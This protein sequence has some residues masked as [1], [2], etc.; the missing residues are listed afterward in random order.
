[1]S[2]ISLKTPGSIPNHKLQRNLQL[3]SKFISNDGGDEGITIDNSGNTTLSAIAEIGSDTDKF[4]MSDSG[5]VKY[6][7][8]DNLKTFIGVGSGDITG[9][10]IT[11]DSG[12]GSKAE[13][14]G[15][16]ADFSILGSSGVGVTNSGT[17]ITAVA[18]PAEIDHDS[19]NN[20]VANEHIDHTSITLTAG[21]GLTGGGDI[22]SNRS[23]AV[24][25]DDST[26]E[27]NS[28]SLRVKDDGI[29]YAKIQNMTDARMLG[30]NAGSDGVI[31]EMTQANVLSFLGVEAGANNVT[32]HVTNDANDTMAGDLT[33]DS[34]GTQLKLQHN[35][36]DYATFTVANTGD[37]TIATIGDGTTDS[38]LI[39]DADGDIELNADGGDITF[40]DASTS[41]GSIG[42]AGL[43]LP[44]DSRVEWG[45]AAD[46]IYADASD[47]HISKDD[48][49][50]VTFKDDQVL[51]EV[52][53]KIKEAASAVAD[54]A[55]YG[56]I[57]IKTAT[58]NELYFTNDAGNDVQIT[59][60]SGL[61]NMP[62]VLYTQ[63]Q[64]DV[65]INKHYLPL[66]GYFEQS[67]V[68]NEPTGMIAPFNMKLQKATMRCNTDISGATWKLGMWALSSGTS[69]SHHHTNGMNWATV[70]GGATHTNAT[71]DFTGTLGDGTNA[72]GGSNAVTAGQWIDFAL[73]SDTDV[74]SSTAEF[75]ITLFFIA[76]LSNTI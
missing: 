61:A 71:F 34:T 2:R 10:S 27:I 35:S 5:V 40:K 70:T 76:D 54:T 52:P 44:T 13:D 65:G 57:W 67:S 20:F 12:S 28:D 46:F 64:D 60:G 41:Y 7:T 17:T 53:I 18:V 8:G 33:I 49:D 75:W 59:S 26:I 56:Q 3:N 42:S 69:E 22:S 72:S 36:N 62:F 58:P 15:G 39:L 32:N 37:L 68:G 11:T 31:T 43:N 74:T 1:M 6:V 14:T 63:F 9:V 66:R 25:V 50:I 73:Q 29:T 47:I 55:A 16:S 48:T 30:N 21:D 19:L 4:L 24:S 38:D 51:N 45:D 23:F